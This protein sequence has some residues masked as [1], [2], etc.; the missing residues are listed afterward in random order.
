MIDLDT[1]KLAALHAAATPGEWK[2]DYDPLDAQDY[3]T[4]IVTRDNRLGINT[5]I[6]RLERNWDEVVH[7]ERRISWKEAEANAALIAFL[8][9]SVPAI[10]ALKAERDALR[11]VLVCIADLRRKHGKGGN[12]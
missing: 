2:T 1:E 5:W 10:L 7:G 9:N 3:A 8:R 12:P 6:G 11:E 4:L